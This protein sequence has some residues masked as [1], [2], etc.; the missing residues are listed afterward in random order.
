MKNMKLSN[1]LYLGFG[2]MVIIAGVLGYMGWSS[3]GKVEHKVTIG[4]EANRFV[5]IIEEARIAEKNFIIR[6]D[7]KYA[8]EMLGQKEHFD[9]L[10][11]EITAQMKVAADRELVAEMHGEIGVYIDQAKHYVELANKVA[12]LTDSSGPITQSARTVQKMAAD[13][14]QDQIRKLNVVMDVQA[15]IAEKS[16]DHLNWAGA[17]KDFLADKDATLNV[18]TDGHKC[19]FGQWLESGELE[20]Q[21]TLCGNEFRQLM[22]GMKQKHLELHSSV[23]EVADARKGAADTSLD[24]YQKK[25]GPILVAILSDF[26]KAEEILKVR[27]SERLAN[28]RDAKRINELALETRRQ[29]KN[30]FLR[31]TD[32][33]IEKTHSHADSL[34]AL[35]EGL[36]SRF[37]QQINKDQAQH[38]IDAV[39]IYRK[40]FADVVKYEGEQ[41]VC[42]GNMVAAAR[43]VTEE[44]TNLRVAKKAEMESVTANSNFIMITLAIAGVVLGAFLAFVITRGITKPVNNIIAGLTD[45]SEQVAA[46][47]GQVSS[48]SQS[49]AEGASE[50]AASLEETSASLEEMASM[51]KLNADN[52][53]QANLLAS[54]ASGSAD[55]GSESM[56]RMTEAINEIQKSSEETA[57]IIK[58]IDEIAF[59][60]NLLALNAA[61][62]AARAGEAGKGFAV[63]AEEVRNLAQRSAEAAKNTNTMIA[64]S[65]KNSENGVKISEEVAKALG[66][67]VTGVGKT[68]DLVSEIAT[69]S[70]EQATGIEQINTAMG[71]MDKVTQQNAANAEESASAS[72]ELSAQAEQMNSIVSELAVLVHG[73]NSES[74]K[75]SRRHGSGSLTKTDHAYHE[76]AGNKSGAKVSSMITT[77]KKEK[78]QTKQAIPLDDDDFEDF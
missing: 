28:S 59:Q 19:A 47:S 66:E 14:S 57:K 41:K 18:E 24:V 69:A 65:V 58:V 21:L 10:V 38:V 27:V 3:L 68:T 5:K 60:T 63:V 45:G 71:Q 75:N 64:E 35:T 23:I 55:Q 12:E 2:I 8:E 26:M 31:G 13:M 72:E 40:A 43:K 15:N 30:Y 4:D 52:A 73:A 32:E 50:Q 53:E 56:D 33:C 42:E 51:T 9:V 62:E 17:V 78:S 70:K 29:E 46:A 6:G 76:I 44:A 25:T 7:E 54:E 61:V 34:I 36:K 22:N 48:A 1:K 37:N 11:E 67:I 16:R 77:A 49:L 39:V 74:S 20:E